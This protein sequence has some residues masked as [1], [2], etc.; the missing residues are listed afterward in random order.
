MLKKLNDRNNQIIVS[1]IVI[2]VIFIL[3]LAVLTV[4]DGEKYREISE[5]RRKKNIPVIAKRG[6]IFDRNGELLA[7]NKSSFTVQ[8]L[9]SDLPNKNLNEIA[10]KII[11]ILDNFNEKHIEFPIIIENGKYYYSFDREIEQWLKSKGKEYENLKDAKAV[12]NKIVAENIPIKNL[13]VYKAQE[14]LA[15]MGITPPISVKLMKF[16]PEIEKDNFLKSYGLDEKISAREAF[17]KIRE[18]FKIS[19]K[20]TDE[21]ARKILIIRHALKEQGYKKY[22]PLKI[23]SGISEKTAIYIEELGM[24]LPGI[25]VVIEPIRYYPNKELAAHVIGYLGKISRESEIEKYVKKNGYLKSDI[26]GKTG[27]EGKYELELKGKNGCKSVEVDAYGR[28]VKE[29]E[30]VNKPISGKD[31]YLTID[32]NLQRTAQES[33]KKALE[34]IQRGGVFKSKWGDYRYSEAFKNAKSGAVVAVNVK[35]GEV[36]ALANYPSYDPN[37]FATGISSEDWAKLQPENKRDPIAPRPLY[38][39]ATLTAVQP[40]STFKMITGLAGLEKGLDPNRKFY[41][42]GYLKRGNKT[43]GSW[44]WNLYRTS[45]G[46]VDL[47]KALEESVN[48]YF[49]NLSNGQINARDSKDNKPLGIDINI[50]DILEYAKKFGLGEK[51]GIEIG[52]VSYGVPTPNKKA[53]TIKT[54]LKRKLKSIAKDYFTEKVLSSK[55]KLNEVI[56]K[57]VSWAD[58][59]PKRYEIANRMK[60]IGV[61]EEKINE[62][63]DL[64]KYSYYNQMKFREGDGFNLA[65]G[66]GAHAYTPIQMARYISAIANGGYLNKLTLV[67]KIG[68]EEINNNKK[69]KIKLVNDENLKHIMKGMLQVTQGDKGTARKV[70]KKFPVLVGAKT[71]TAEKSGK[72]PPKDEVEYLKKHLKYISKN[73]SLDMVEKESKKIYESRKKELEKLQKEGKTDE[74]VNKLTKGYIDEGNIMREAIKKLSNYK[75]TNEMIDRFKEN[76]DNFSWFVSFAPYEDPQIAVVVLLVQGGHGGY[77]A[78]IAREVIAEY[79][80]LNKEVSDNISSNEQK[81]ESE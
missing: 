61:K 59:N 13:D 35:T 43:F 1:F 18:K 26:I 51:T 57:I 81:T 28:T 48:T 24:E 47:Y 77:G 80:G 44:K 46:Y 72:I 69:V 29:Y 40:G 60:K 73:L 62:L 67:K 41:D 7:G 39:I 2:F 66:Q 10:I 22:K 8:M 74:V 65:I 64:V 23:A 37:L 75:I 4:V 63:T 56:D 12:F 14:I 55:E 58:E 68:N 27:I 54:L 70:F 79:L 9:R 25:S 15:Y 76:Y 5:N 34:A 50:G 3:R 52:E 31:I 42:V 30:Y 19:T 6:E 36:L 20:Y 53:L 49:F 32:A 78:P 45:H 11:D 71:G 33:L 38:N 16:L 21:E 17:K